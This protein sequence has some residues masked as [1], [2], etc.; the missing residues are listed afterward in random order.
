MMQSL[1]KRIEAIR[2]YLPPIPGVFAELAELLQDDDVDLR[3]L[4][5]VIAKDPSMAVNVLRLANSAFY[6]LANKV[7]TLEHAVTML[8]IREITSLCMACQAARIFKPAHGEKT[9]DLQSFWRHSVATGVLAKVFC[10]EFRITPNSQAYLAGLMHDVGKIILDRFLHSEYRKVVQLTF[11]ENMALIEAEK[12]VLGETHA[13]VGGWLI[14]KWKL[15]HLF[16]AV[17][18][19]HHSIGRAPAES[20]LMVAVVSLADL[21][22]RLKGFGFGGDES[23]VILEEAE[24]FQI[25]KES[26][27]HLAELDL[28][29]FIMDLDRTDA[30][31]ARIQEMLHAT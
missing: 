30:D 25:I 29:S 28:A 9:I 3:T 12:Q 13:T 8:G 16:G 21:V 1:R 14:E 22:A 24:A 17:T 19:F 18:S 27:P 5:G 23:G 4:G 20:R 31:I 7:K 26:H 15:P 11:D 2:T 10:T 6:G